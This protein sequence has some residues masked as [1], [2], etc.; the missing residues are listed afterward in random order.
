MKPAHHHRIG[1]LVLLQ[2]PRSQPLQEDTRSG[3]GTT[4]GRPHQWCKGCM[5]HFPN[6]AL[7][8]V[9][10]LPFMSTIH[11]GQLGGRIREHVG[12]KYPNIKKCALETT[13]PEATCND[14][15]T[16]SISMCSSCGWKMLTSQRL[17]GWLN[18]DS[19]AN[20]SEQGGTQITQFHWNRW[21][22]WNR[23]KATCRARQ[24]M[25]HSE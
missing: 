15:Q 17:K 14:V 9:A 11:V 2:K 6:T 5:L 21:F 22:R 3:A 19:R 10:L 16:S 7:V 8:G 18:S 12:I 23:W 24:C 4:R 1:L 25:G 20:L 13:T